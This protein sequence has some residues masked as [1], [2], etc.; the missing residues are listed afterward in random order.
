VYPQFPEWLT[1]DDMRRFARLVKITSGCDVSVRVLV[2]DF[3]CL[4][5]RIALPHEQRDPDSGKKSGNLA[6]DRRKPVAYKCAP[7]DATRSI[8]EMVC[9]ALIGR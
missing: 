6:V 1:H 8:G 3:H 4:S 7:M 9:A 5:R 2:T